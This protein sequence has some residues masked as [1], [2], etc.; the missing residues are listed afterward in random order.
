MLKLLRALWH[1]IKGSFRLMLYSLTLIVGGLYALA[2]LAPYIPPVYTVVPAVLGLLFPLVLG[3]YLVVSGCWVVLRRWR[4]V[5][6][7]GVIFALS[8]PSVLAYF[9]LNRSRDTAPAEGQSALR[10]LSYN[11]NAFGFRRHSA[12]RPNPVL[13]YIKT[14]EADVVCLQE[15]LLT[16]SPRQGVTFK[17]L[18]QYLGEQYPHIQR[19]YAQ[20]HG[21]SMLILLS[22][23]PINY[24]KRL[25]LT[26]S[27]N[28]GM[29]YRV[30]M[31]DGETTVVNLH[32]ES[33]RLKKRDGETY[34]QFLKDRNALGLKDAIRGKFAPTFEAHN[35]QANIIQT[36]IAGEATE[37]IIVCGDFN[38]TPLSYTRHKIASGLSDA[39]VEAGRGAGISFSTWFFLVR[40]DHILLGQAFEPV[41]CAVDRSIHAS[42]HYPIRADVLYSPAP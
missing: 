3:G 1:F 22:K 14:S 4:M 42:D 12:Q 19:N 17:Q 29:I 11:V 37:R 30:Q 2:I 8:L 21:G 38:D 20:E 33:F 36:I 34:L 13:Q 25:P 9:P 6:I 10:I 39:F 26:S 28:G 32:L 23:F 7:L 24:S 5:L 41:A 15:A 18:T 27:A 35:R 16:D 31:P 40:I